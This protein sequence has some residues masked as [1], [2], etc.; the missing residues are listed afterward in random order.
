[1][2]A[3]YIAGLVLILIF[4]FVAGIILYTMFLFEPFYDWFGIKSELFTDKVFGNNLDFFE[5][6]LVFLIYM[7]I[8]L[9][10]FY[11]PYILLWFIILTLII[12]AIIFS[13]KK[14]RPIR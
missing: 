14:V 4:L 2:K 9:I 13:R 5:G 3:L 7:I 6:L 11:F 8:L 1:M 12:T 10:L